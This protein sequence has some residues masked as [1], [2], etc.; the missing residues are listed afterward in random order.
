MAYIFRAS[1]LQGT[2]VHCMNYERDTGSRSGIDA[3]VITTEEYNGSS[4]DRDNSIA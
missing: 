1:D 3:S 4:E 2:A